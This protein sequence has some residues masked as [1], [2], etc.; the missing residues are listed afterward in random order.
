MPVTMNLLILDG[1]AMGFGGKYL[2]NIYM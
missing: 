1:F 2:M